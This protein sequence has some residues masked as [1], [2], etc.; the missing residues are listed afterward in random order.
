MIQDSSDFQT[1]Y[2]N[3]IHQKVDLRE[4]GAVAVKTEEEKPAVEHD[5]MMGEMNIESKFEIDVAR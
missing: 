2:L 1:R 3:A 5:M 4:N